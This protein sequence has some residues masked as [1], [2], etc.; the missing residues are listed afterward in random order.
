MQDWT[1]WHA[2]YADPTSELSRRLV[3]VQ[4]AIRGWADAQ[5]PGPLRVLSLCAG[6]AHDIVGA[7]RDHSRRADVSGPLVELD[8]DNVAVA[9]AALLAAGLTGLRAVVGDAGTTTTFHQ[10]LPCDLAIVCGVF[11]NISD[12]DVRRTISA[13]P[14]MCRAGGTVVWTRHRRSPDLTPSIRDWFARSGFQ[15]QAFVSPGPERFAVGV[16]RSMRPAAAPS[17]RLFTFLR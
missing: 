9:N 2:A 17:E 13:L 5:P 14:S 8:A 10:A 16:H 15:E 7:L 3:V 11:G 12:D 6:Q 4:Q 1:R